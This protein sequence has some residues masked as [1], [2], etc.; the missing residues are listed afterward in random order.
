MTI[1]MKLSPSTLVLSYIWFCL[2]KK[3]RSETCVNSSGTTT[4]RG[5]LVVFIFIFKI[6]TPP[7]PCIPRAYCFLPNYNPTN[8]IELEYIVKRKEMQTK[9]KTAEREE[10]R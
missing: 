9:E 6:A 5:M 2:Q 3:I 7:P 4:N 1:Q 10:K 8:K